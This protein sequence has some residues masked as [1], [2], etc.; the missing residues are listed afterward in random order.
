MGGQIGLT[1]RPE[2]TGSIFWFTAKFQKMNALNDI[3]RLSSQLAN[4]KLLA[5]NPTLSA[6]LRKSFSTKNVLLAEDNVINQKVMVKMLRSL[7]VERIDIAPDG[8]KAIIFVTENPKYY[9][10]ILMDVSMPVLDGLSATTRLRNAGFDLPIIAL[11]ANALKGDREEFLAR[12]MNDHV[13]KPVN[14]D[15]LAETLARWMVPR[16]CS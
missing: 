13:P 11:T 2:A 15:I 12:G 16:A 10:I 9:D 3:S 1:P 8:A 5:Q 7:G 4:T 6:K 14:R